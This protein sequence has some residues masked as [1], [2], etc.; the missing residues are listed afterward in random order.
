MVQKLLKACVRY[1]DQISIFSPNDT[2][3]KTM[4]NVL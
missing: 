3:L 4:K 1:F 2:P